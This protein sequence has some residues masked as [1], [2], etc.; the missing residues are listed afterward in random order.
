MTKECAHEKRE[1]KSWKKADVLQEH[2]SVLTGNLQ[3]QEK[4]KGEIV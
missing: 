2:I 4:I 1:M 3:R